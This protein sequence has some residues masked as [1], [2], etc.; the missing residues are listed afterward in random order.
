VRILETLGRWLPP[1]GLM[2]V[3]YALSAQPHLDSGLGVVDLIARKLVHMAEFGLLAFL[4]WRP[5]RGHL[6]PTPALA[7]SFALAVAY[8][9]TD[10]Y[11]QTFI[12]GRNGTITDL[13]IDAAGAALAI[14]LI[15]WRTRT[16]G[17]AAGAR[18]APTP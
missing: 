1:L 7:T 5:L 6:H 13:L 18:R 15:A 3:I 16:D 11:H 9:A 8:A 2:A 4:W 17:D 14:A 10:E 12:A